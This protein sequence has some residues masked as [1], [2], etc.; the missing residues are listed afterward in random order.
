VNPRIW[1]L[2]ERAHD[3]LAAAADVLKTE[4]PWRAATDAYYAMFHAA[5]ALLLSLGIE[6]SSHSA[7]QAAFG[8]QFAKTGRLDTKL[9]RYLLNAYDKRIT[10]DYDV[11]VKLRTDEVQALVAQAEEF[12]AAAEHHLASDLDS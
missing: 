7:A 12:V 6:T 4:R 9:H 8:Q 5:E 3:D 1:L 10:A 11:T 2:L